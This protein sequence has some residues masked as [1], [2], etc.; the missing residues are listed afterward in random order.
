MR[1]YAVTDIFV[2]ADSP[3]K[4]D[5]GATV[6]EAMA[7]GLPVIC[8]DTISSQADL[9]RRGEN[10]FVYRLG[11]LDALAEFIKKLVID[12]KFLESMKKKSIEIISNWDY[13]Q[14]IDELVKA[15]KFI[16]KKS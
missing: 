11:D 10:G 4:G 7:C 13:K 16:K 15:L 8:T 3:H 6:N 5:W 2:R 1:I 12:S 14:D 9:I